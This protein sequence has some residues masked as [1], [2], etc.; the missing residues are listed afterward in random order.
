MPDPRAQDRTVAENRKARHDYHIEE[1]V[2]AGLVLSGTEIKSIRAG[3]VHLREAYARV[4]RGEA[5]LFN[6]HVSPYD[7]GNRW[8]HEPLRARK[9]LLHRRQ[10]EGLAQRARQQG[11]TI[12]PLRLLLRGGRA[13]VELALARGKHQYDKRAS[14]AERDAARR[15]DRALKER[16]R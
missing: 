14:I 10:I 12:V 4:E 1:T 16:A 2:E 6:M 9:L 7:F 3:R 13:K 8:N 15:I 11:C 5:W